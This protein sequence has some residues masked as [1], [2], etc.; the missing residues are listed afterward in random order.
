MALPALREEL[1]LMPGAN[2]PDGQPTWTLHDPVRNRYFKIDWLTLSILQRWWL[3]DA[4]EIVEAVDNETT[5][6]AEPADVDRV[7]TFLTD[8]ELVQRV[9]GEHARQMA[10][11]LKKIQGTVFGWLI[12]HYL[13]FRI[14]LVK[15]DR[16]L[17]RMLPVA[18]FFYSRKFLMTTLVVFGIGAFEVARNWDSFSTSLVDTFNLSGFLSYGVTLVAVKLF[19][20]LG[21]AFTAKRY[22][23]R[24][25]AMGLAFLVMMPV[26][27]TDTNDTWRLTDRMQRLHVAMAGVATEL[28]IATWATLAWALL[29]DGALRSS[30]FFLATTS[31]IATVAINASPFMRFDGYF[32]ASDWFDMPNLHERS[33]AL[34]RWHLREVLFDLR[35]DRPEHF[36]RRKEIVMIAFAWGIWIYRL[37]LF[38]G[39]AV[40]VYHF[41][42]KAVGIMLFA[43]EIGWFVLKPLKQEIM[44]W[45]PRWPVIASRS[46]SRRSALIAIILVSLVFVPWPSR[47]NAS[48]ILRPLETMPVVAPQGAQ[49]ERAPLPEGTVVSA[50]TPVVHLLAPELESR[51]N[52]LKAKLERLRWQASSAGLDAESRSRMQSTQVE[53]TAAQAELASITEELALYAPK[54]PWDG[55]VRDVDPDLQAGEWLSRKERIAVLVRNGAWVVET[56]LDEDEVKRVAIGDAARFFTDGGSGPSLKLKVV[57]VDADATRVLPNG[58]LAAPQGGHILA[59]EKNNQ[60]IPEQAMYR[61]ML[62]VEEAPG[63]LATHAWRG[64]L[65]ISGAWQVPGWRYLRNALAILVRESG[66]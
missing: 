16:W 49:L 66:M 22:G 14:P 52:G 38:L 23:C 47:I 29:P 2:L 31:W 44:A 39:I 21:H 63:P 7:V 62:A 18:D 53:L 6:H 4:N 64:K 13:F 27:Y 1:S 17:Q 36:S 24:V 60:I 40:L 46:R 61:V 10:E 56:Y 35:E 41:F 9:G 8:N 15:P 33:F 34:A 58:M 25:P 50:G 19:H 51:R 20:E 57:D 5:L 45:K 30:A 3:D 48:G 37:T 11:R 65:A 26:A 54:A 55:V 32:I 43:I 12:H 42:V 59:R 28:I